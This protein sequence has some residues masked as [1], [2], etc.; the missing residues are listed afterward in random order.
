[1]HDALR[2]PLPSTEQLRQQIVSLLLAGRKQEALDV[3]TTAIARMPDIAGFR[4]FKAL[5][6]H[7]LGR[8]E[9]AI[10]TLDPVVANAMTRTAPA[11]LIRGQA[12]WQVGRQ[13][14]AVEALEA[15]L[16]LAPNDHRMH[17]LLG[18]YCLTLGDFERGWRGYEHR[19]ARLPNPRPDLKRWTGEDL[20]GKRMLVISEQ[21]LGDTL[22][23]LR[24]LPPLRER[25][26]S[27]T[28]VIQPSLLDLSRT[29]DA[30]VAWTGDLK[31]AGAFDLR[32]DLLSLPLMF[33]TRMET[34]PQRIPYLTADAGK[35]AAWAKA[36]GREGFRIGVAWQ[37]STGP[38]RDD[39]RSIPP[40]LFGALAEKRD[41]RLISLQGITGLEPLASLPAGVIIERLGPKIEANRDGISEIAAVMENLD[42]VITSDTMIAH[43]AGALGRPVWVGLKLNADWRWLRNRSDS[44]WYP[45]MRLFRQERAGDWSAVTSAMAAQLETERTSKTGCG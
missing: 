17:E 34:I 36:L 26:A 10:L 37:G 1:M 29:V 8:H 7:E 20:A 42:L 28:A 25:G 22:Q 27:V 30:G 4:V 13:G 41:V 21:G 40:A 6:L 2:R 3:S 38:M 31:A 43:L 33:G 23:F 39:T 12:L 14:E 19:L 16:S 15:G 11:Y 35:V 18:R 44:P 32:M 45:T 9:D 5:C 24:F